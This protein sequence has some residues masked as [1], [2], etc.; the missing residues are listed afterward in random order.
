M[1]GSRLTLLLGTTGYALNIGSYLSVSR[2][3][4]SYLP[5]ISHT[6]SALNIHPNAKG[7]VIGSG[8]ILG[9]CAGLLWT[10]Q[11]SLMMAYPTEGQKG[12][13]VGV[14]WGIFNLGGVVGSSVAL[15]QNIHSTVRDV[16][17]KKTP[18]FLTYLVGQRR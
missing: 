1:I 12:I 10:A 16:R 14:F 15:G 17:E 7:F 5:L 9:L 3:L 13:F 2:N 6:H 8:A 18:K 11:G 4:H